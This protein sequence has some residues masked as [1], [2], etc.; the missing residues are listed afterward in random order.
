MSSL[1]AK[2][3]ND[4]ERFFFVVRASGFVLSPR[5]TE[6]VRQWYLKGVPMRVV[7]EGI[8]EGARTHAYKSSPGE[9]LP[10]QLSF[11][12][13]FIGGR[14]RAFNRL[15][16]LPD[17]TVEDENE[18]KSYVSQLIAELRLLTMQ[19]ER[20]IEREV[21]GEL[22]ERLEAL[23]KRTDAELDEGE[24]FHELQLLDDDILALYH[25]RLAAD[26]KESIARTCRD[27]MSRERGLSRKA[28]EGRYRA[29]EAQTLR[30]RLNLM[31]LAK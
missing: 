25:S 2:Y 31:E 28:M 7:M 1:F 19:E 8:I 9:K 5:D 6:K 22:L 29:L 11:Y 26:E 14:V 12:S 23:G 17:N 30:E 4:V 24:L 16:V 13:R 18:S 10:H 3:L 27:R 20:A 21:K 15:P